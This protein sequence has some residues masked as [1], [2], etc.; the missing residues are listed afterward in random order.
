MGPPGWVVGP[1]VAIG[2]LLFAMG[3]PLAAMGSAVIFPP[4]IAMWV[5]AAAASMIDSR[6]RL[7][8]TLVVVTTLAVFLTYLIL[9]QSQP[10]P[11][12]TSHGAASVPAPPGAAKSG[13][14]VPPP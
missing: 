4:V 10:L 12:G 5:G 2:T 1:V 6:H 11:P 9:L 7:N 14:N 3:T 8:T 13:F